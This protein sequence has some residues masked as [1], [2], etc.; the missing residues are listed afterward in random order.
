MSVITVYTDL[1]TLASTKEYL[2][3]D[4]DITETDDEITQLI[5]SAC[6]IIE[7]YTQ[8]YLKP[9]DITYFFN[10][11][12]CA[13][14]YA[15]PINTITNETSYTRTQRQLYSTFTTTDASLDSITMNVGHTDTDDVKAIFIHAVQELVRMW[16]YQSETESVNKGIL[17]EKIIQIV[18]Q[19]RRFIF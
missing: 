12:E 1:V 6:N 11:R 14:V 18:S 19:E 15:F 13:R 17:P 2:R 10:V 7:S 5:N 8:V 16:F 3:I 4:T 9:R